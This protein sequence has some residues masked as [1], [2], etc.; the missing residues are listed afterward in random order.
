MQ[1]PRRIGLVATLAAGFAFAAGAHDDKHAKDEHAK[2]DAHAQ[3]D[4]TAHGGTK[5]IDAKTAEPLVDGMEEVASAGE[6]I[7]T[8]A[9]FFERT[10]SAN[11]LEVELGKLAQ[12][13]S[14]KASVDTFAQRMVADHSKKID[15]LEGLAAKKNV[16][17]PTALM[18]VHRETLD[19]LGALSG[20]EFDE[21]Y[22]DFMVRA[23]RDMEQLLLKTAEQ[24]A[25][26]DIRTFA[27]ETAK[28]VREHYAHAQKLDAEQVTA[29]IE[30]DE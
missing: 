25:D 27:N 8:D 10:A 2:D 24:T 29:G 19:R 6:E 18:P 17:L 28:G 14:A 3:H 13:K 20:A 16:V 12:K 5:A 23:H 15:E 21:G 26:D 7:I 1:M 9:K 30:E 11:M 22:T 4:P